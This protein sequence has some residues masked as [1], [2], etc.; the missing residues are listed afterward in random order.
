MKR[1]TVGILIFDGV[2]V[3][4][5]AGPFEILSAARVSH[6]HGFAGWRDAHAPFSVF[7]V[8]KDKRVIVSSGGLRIEPAHG[9]DDHPPIDVVI[10]PGGA[11]VRSI[12]DFDRPDDTTLQW[13]DKVARTAQLVT[14]VCT[15]AWV[16]AR[17]GLLRNRRATTHFLCHDRLAELDPTIKVIRDQR[18]VEDGVITS[19]GVASG[20]D[21][22]LHLVRK[23]CGQAAAHAT[24]QY[25][26]YPYANA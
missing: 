17:A 5:F 26:E 13:I 6:A 14:S 3:L 16:L 4:D 21:M 11:G 15:G 9:F 23:L 1:H 12:I 25:I 10:I 22:A 8:A 18:I 2:E 19:A 7:T 20:L 24:A